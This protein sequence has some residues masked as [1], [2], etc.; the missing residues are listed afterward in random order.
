V[1]IG[2]GTTGQLICTLPCVNGG[3]CNIINGQQQV[4]LCPLGFSGANCEI[5]GWFIHFYKN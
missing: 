4:C 1:H 5:Q 3:V 2:S